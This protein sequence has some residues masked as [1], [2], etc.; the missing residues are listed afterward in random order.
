MDC[1]L[2]TRIGICHRTGELIHSCSRSTSKKLSVLV[3][4]LFFDISPCG[5]R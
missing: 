3:V 4:R 2:V 1:T 5:I